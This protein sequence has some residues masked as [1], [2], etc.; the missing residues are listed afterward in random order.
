MKTI[1]EL[2]ENMRA[3]FSARIGAAVG[4]G[5]DL[6]ARMYA[7]A[8]QIYALQV[9]RDWVRR[10]CFPPDGPGRK[11]GSPRPDALPDA[12]AGHPRGGSRPFLRPERGGDGPNHPGRDGVYDGGI[13]A[14]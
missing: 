13:G 1:E 6:A 7:L 3:D 9:H 12:Q 14:L 4:D 5:C 11:S 10:Q 2:Y 8:A